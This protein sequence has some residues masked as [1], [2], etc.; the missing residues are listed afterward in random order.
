[1]TDSVPG[2]GVGVAG[3][4][5]TVTVLMEPRCQ[6][7]RPARDTW[8]YEQEIGPVVIERSRLQSVVIG[9]MGGAV[10]PELPEKTSR[11]VTLKRRAG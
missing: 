3:T 5:D 6:P 4:A 1:M 11:E 8:I 7:G 2:T 9:R 10:R